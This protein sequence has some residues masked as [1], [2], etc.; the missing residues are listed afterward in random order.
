[1]GN[2]RFIILH[3]GSQMNPIPMTNKTEKVFARVK[4]AEKNELLELAEKA[5]QRPSEIVREALME[6]MA[7]LRERFKKPLQ[8]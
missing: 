2:S 8:N 3:I 5:D 6:K 1:M 7:A 4:L